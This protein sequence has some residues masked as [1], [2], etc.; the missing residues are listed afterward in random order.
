[1]RHSLAWSYDL[2]SPTE[3][4]LFRRLA[5]FA[6]GCTAEA[7]EAVCATPGSFGPRDLE[8]LNGLEALVDHSV[9]QRLEEGDSVRRPV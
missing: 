5:V 1:M 3:Q 9:V 2:L 7:A 6:G 8:W 4:R